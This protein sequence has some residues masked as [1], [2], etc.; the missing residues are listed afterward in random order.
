MV[1]QK[2]DLSLAVRQCY[3][4]APF[5]RLDEAYVLPD[6]VFSCCD[7]NEASRIMQIT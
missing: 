7:A 2:Q 1:I 3:I 4:D 6:W 5:F